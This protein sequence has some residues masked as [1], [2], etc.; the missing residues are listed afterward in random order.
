MFHFAHHIYFTN[1][2]SLK[3]CF[4]F[5]STATVK[6]L[7]RYNLITILPRVDLPMSSFPNLVPNEQHLRINKQL[8]VDPG[9]WRRGVR[10]SCG[11]H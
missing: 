2:T 6:N 4:F 3:C 1:E 11:H 5:R 8:P 9:R 7:Y 10:A